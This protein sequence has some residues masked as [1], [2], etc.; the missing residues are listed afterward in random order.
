MGTSITACY[1]SA[2]GENQCTTGVFSCCNAVDVKDSRQNTGMDG[3]L[4][5]QTHFV[6]NVPT[7]LNQNNIVEGKLY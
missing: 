4:Q 6:T 3:D 7:Y 1:S 5:G 2:C